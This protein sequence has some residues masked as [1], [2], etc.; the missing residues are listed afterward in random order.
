M[1]FPLPMDITALKTTLRIAKVK[2]IEEQLA[3][4]IMH[5][6]SHGRAIK[7]TIV[8]ILTGWDF[9]VETFEYSDENSAA[10]PKLRLLCLP[11]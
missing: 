9:Q 1:H 11:T 7:Q 3:C 6:T 10:R 4:N 8:R 2:N 5:S